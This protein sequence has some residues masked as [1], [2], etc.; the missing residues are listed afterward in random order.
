MTHL[1]IWSMEMY[2]KPRAAL[3]RSS[4]QFEWNKN[5]RN[6]TGT[7]ACSLMVTPETE[8]QFRHS[9]TLQGLHVNGTGR[10]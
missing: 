10:R 9:V 2:G 3:L 5:M 8:N 4:F 6:Y 7:A 1:S